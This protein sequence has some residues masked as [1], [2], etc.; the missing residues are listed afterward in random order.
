ME[1]PRKRDLHR[2]LGQPDFFPLVDKQAEV[3]LVFVSV[4]ARRAH[5][6]QDVLSAEILR[7]GYVVPLRAEKEVLGTLG[8]AL[9]LRMQEF[10]KWEPTNSDNVSKILQLRWKLNKVVDPAPSKDHVSFVPHALWK[11]VNLEK[12]FNDLSANVPLLQ[13]AKQVLLLCHQFLR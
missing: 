9:K 1:K 13:L 2:A 3:V 10:G 4:A 5:G 7:K 6:W 11:P 12:W 8:D